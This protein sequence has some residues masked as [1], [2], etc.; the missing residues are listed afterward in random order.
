VLS[1]NRST[2]SFPRDYRVTSTSVRIVILFKAC[3]DS[4]S[5]GRP[6]AVLDVKKLL[7][8]LLLFK[9]LYGL[10]QLCATVALFSVLYFFKMGFFDRREDLKYRR[11]SH[12]NVLAGSAGRN[13]GKQAQMMP[14]FC[15]IITQYPLWKTFPLTVWTIRRMQATPTLGNLSVKKRE[16]GQGALTSLQRGKWS[17]PQSSFGAKAVVF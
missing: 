17:R 6:P 15:W 16:W 3:P 11:L 9:L 1:Y 14:V 4:K 13:V 7:S 8:I 12:T 10:S 2:G 5:K